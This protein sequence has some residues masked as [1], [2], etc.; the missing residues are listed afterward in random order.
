[1][2][3]QVRGDCQRVRRMGEL[4]GETVEVGRP[5]RSHD[6]IWLQ[7]RKLSSAA[8]FKFFITATW[9]F[10]VWTDFGTTSDGRRFNYE[11]DFFF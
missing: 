5:K 2:L 7:L 3:F 8:F 10:F 11:I 6:V 1:M 4:L 9:A